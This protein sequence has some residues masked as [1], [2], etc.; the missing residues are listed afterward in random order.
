MHNNGALPALQ[1]IIKQHPYGWRAIPGSTLDPS[2]KTSAYDLVVSQIYKYDDEK[3]V[4]IVMTWSFDGIRRGAHP[5]ESCYYVNGF[6]VSKARNVSIIIDRQK[7]E[8]IAFTGRHGYINEDVIYW[9]VT[10][11][12][13][14]VTLGENIPLRSRAKEIAQVLIGD[15]PSNLMVRV[16]TWRPSTD[17]PSTAHIDYIKSYLQSL[18]PKTRHF[19]TGL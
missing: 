1:K 2:T 6:T 17:P 9:R 14:D 12:K 8:L 5:Q 7:L 18:D 11:G 10:G 19:L 3:V 4:S 15:I 16:S 13:H